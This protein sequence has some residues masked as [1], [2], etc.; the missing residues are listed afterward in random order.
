MWRRRL[1]VGTKRNRRLEND[2]GFYKFRCDDFGDN[3]LTL[4]RFQH[5][6]DACQPFFCLI[7]FDHWTQIVPA[8]EDARCT[9]LHSR[10]FPAQDE[11]SSDAGSGS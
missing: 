3:G 9:L 2:Q 10:V 7:G 4:K 6:L 1:A 5:V 11:P 8:S